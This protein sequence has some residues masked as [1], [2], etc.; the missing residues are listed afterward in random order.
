[1]FLLMC[2]CGSGGHCGSKKRPS[3]LPLHT[4][5][6]PGKSHCGPQQVQYKFLIIEVFS[7]SA[8]FCLCFE[9]GCG[10]EGQHELPQKGACIITQHYAGKTAKNMVRLQER[11]K[12][13]PWCPHSCFIPS[14]TP[15]GNTHFPVSCS[16]RRVLKNTA[17]GSSHC[18]PNQS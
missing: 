16:F 3:D 18:F 10:N 5:L 14:S 8:A 17:T 1:M 7:P 2:I 13:S 12:D 15:E 4:L 9:L 6:L 11:P